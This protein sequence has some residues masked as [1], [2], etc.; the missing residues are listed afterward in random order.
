MNWEESVGMPHKNSILN[1]IFGMNKV[2]SP[3]SCDCLNKNRFKSCQKHPTALSLLTLTMASARAA[4]Q[5]AAMVC[6][7]PSVRWCGGGASRAVGLTGAG[8]N[9]GGGANAQQ[10]IRRL[11]TGESTAVG[12]SMGGRAAAFRLSSA[13]SLA[14]LG[15]LGTKHALLLAKTLLHDYHEDTALIVDGDMEVEDT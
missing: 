8:H 10:A 1:S 5:L 15:P 14:A 9:P 11:L 4:R 7:P 12:S 13:R 3:V 6:R 2:K